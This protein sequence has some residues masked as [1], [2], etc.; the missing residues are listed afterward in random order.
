MPSTYIRITRLCVQNGAS[1][2]TYGAASMGIIAPA[3]SVT[4]ATNEGRIASVFPMHVHIMRLIGRARSASRMRKSTTKKENSCTQTS[5]TVLAKQKG[6]VTKPGRPDPSSPQLLHTAG[7][8]VVTRQDQRVGC[9]HPGTQQQKCLYQ[10]RSPSEPLT[11]HCTLAIQTLL[12]RIE[13]AIYNR[14]FPAA[15]EKYARTRIKIA[16]ECI[17]SFRAT[18]SMG[19]HA[20]TRPAQTLSSQLVTAERD[21]CGM[22]ETTLDRLWYRHIT[23]RR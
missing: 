12:P 13:S 14:A 2:S 9:C 18:T 20:F 23:R 16:D 3:T 10:Q 1:T 22:R 7:Y 6:Y 4:C 17:Q 8:N 11:S 5:T 15:W 19:D 21:A